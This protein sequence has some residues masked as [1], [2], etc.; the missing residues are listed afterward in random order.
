[1]TTTLIMKIILMCG[2]NQD[3]I[4]QIEG[5]VRFVSSG[6]WALEQSNDPEVRGEIALKVCQRDYK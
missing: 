3:C 1:M 2:I 4:R 6:P 5:C